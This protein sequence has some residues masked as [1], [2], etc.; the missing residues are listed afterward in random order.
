VPELYRGD[1]PR[2]RRGRPGVGHAAPQARA[3]DIAR[4]WFHLPEDTECIHA[5][6]VAYLR[7]TSR[8]C[9]AFG[10]DVFRGPKI[11]AAILTGDIGNTLVV[12]RRPADN[13]RRKSG[14]V[15]GVIV[16]RADARHDPF[17]RC[18]RRA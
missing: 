8:R 18:A 14:S 1:G 4:R 15:C 11:P 16:G 12:C 13:D 10:V 5:D 9:D 2:A 3:F 17:R 7:S 6:A